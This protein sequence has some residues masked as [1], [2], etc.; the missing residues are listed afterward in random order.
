MP[1]LDQLGAKLGPKFGSILLNILNGHKEMALAADANARQLST[2]ATITRMGDEAAMIN[3]ILYKPILDSGQT[4]TPEF[5]AFLRAAVSGSHQVV[6]TVASIIGGTAAGGLGAIVSDALAP[7]VQAYL[8]RAPNLLPDTGSLAA[9]AARGWIT[10]DD[11]LAAIAKQGLN[12]KWGNAL[13]GA[14]RSWPT[15]DVI[16]A[17]VNRGI[18]PENNATGYLQA[19][20]YTPDVYNQLMRL[21]NAILS[22]ADA[23]LAELRGNLDHET[24]LKIAADNGLTPDQYQVVFDNTGEPPPI[25]QMVSLWRR[26]IIETD[27]LDKA[28]RQSRVRDEWIDTIHKFSIIPPSPVDM[29]EAYL[30]GQLDESQAH[31]LYEKLGGDP[32]YFTILYNTRGSSPTPVELGDLANRGI[33]PWDGTG[34]NV[35][36]FQQGFLEGP[37]RNKWLDVFKKLAVYLPPPRTITA[38]V[39]EGSL[40]DEK[41]LELLQAQGLD[42]ELAAAYIVSAHH[43]KT[44]TER[45]LTVSE[46]L[47]LYTDSAIDAQQA[48]GMLVGLGYNQES[49]NF[50]IQYAD[51]QRVRKYF[52][53]AISKVHTLYVNHHISKNDVVN[54]MNAIGAPSGQITQLISLWDLERESNV[55]LLTATQIRSAMKKSLLTQDEAQSR[56]EERGYRPEDAAIFLQL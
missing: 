44:Q 24:A 10:D 18:L 54:Q 17:L 8:E 31:A 9:M 23:A 12:N 41:G 16:F 56:L 5:D 25:D 35:V 52:E 1:N 6:S 11:A 27:S 4:V 33:I 28:I 32:D 22:P 26:G 21:R 47:T 39:R 14:N 55:T 13:L 15:L 19:L 37:W 43:Q 38:M 45:D 3:R 49:A 29:L 42:S 2:W 40:S 51:L 20:G 30:E 36:S 48:G 7:E 34:P 46:I 50:L 53:A